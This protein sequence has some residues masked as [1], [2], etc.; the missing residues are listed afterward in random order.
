L[1]RNLNFGRTAAL[2][3]LTQSTLSRN[4]SMLEK[5]VG[6]QLCVRTSP[7]QITR[8]GSVVLTHASAIIM[9]DELMCAEVLALGKCEALSLVVM[10]DSATPLV[11]SNMRSIFAKMF[12][13]D[14]SL[15]ITRYQ[16]NG[17][18]VIDALLDGSIDIGYYC[19]V[20]ADTNALQRLSSAELESHEIQG[21]DNRLLVAIPRSHALAGK[22]HLLAEDLHTIEFVTAAN[23]ALEHFFTSV[24]EA[25]ADRGVTLS[26]RMLALNNI[27]DALMV[28]FSD[29]A[30]FISTSYLKANVI[31]KSILE[32]VV[33]REVEDLDLSLH[34]KVIWL[35]GSKNP[36][37]ALLKEHL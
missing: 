10:D 22:E 14:R 29:C 15:E 7:L 28:G 12:E 27:V 16:L 19:H 17:K 3:N 35:K 5:Y 4:I 23:A 8:A 24:N 9:H 30:N 13:K 11:A 20:A 31:P 25:F 6:A 32:H 2:L 18:G 34:H 26:K 36:G 21:L 1:A 33:L 37:I